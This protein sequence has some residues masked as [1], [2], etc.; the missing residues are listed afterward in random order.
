MDREI[1]EKR[2]RGEDIR[3]EGVMAI[4]GIEMGSLSNLCDT[5]VSEFAE[6]GATN[7]VITFVG[8]VFDVEPGSAESDMVIGCEKYT[9]KEEDEG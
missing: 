7:E 3:Q 1:A 4:D 5:C 9:E 6:C 8:E 2:G